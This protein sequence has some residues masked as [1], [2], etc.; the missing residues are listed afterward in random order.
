MKGNSG[1][2][3]PLTAPTGTGI[4]NPSADDEGASFNAGNYPRWFD[5]QAFKSYNYVQY[6]EKYDK[7]YAAL[8]AA[9]ILAACIKLP[10][11]LAYAA[12][13]AGMK[14]GHHAIDADGCGI[15]TRQSA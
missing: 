15:S 11:E 14:N 13:Q 6:C 5:R 9:G 12:S 8:G 3:L 2:T 1:N 7:A 4:P 10:E